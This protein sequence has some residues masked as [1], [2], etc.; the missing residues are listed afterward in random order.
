MPNTIGLVVEVGEKEVGKN[1]DFT[2]QENGAAF[3]LANCTVTMAVQ[4]GT[5]ITFSIISTSAGT[6]RY[7]TVGNIWKAGDYQA[8]IKVAGTS[9]VRL[10]ESPIF[11]L[12]VHRSL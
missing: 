3:N 11:T 1:L 2:V 5:T 4:R 10:F 9:P 7:A 12:R 8:Q 6:I